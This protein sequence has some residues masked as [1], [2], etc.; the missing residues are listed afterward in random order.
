[1]IYLY[2]LTGPF[3]SVAWGVYYEILLQLVW[4]TYINEHIATAGPGDVT[5]AQEIMRGDLST[6]CCEGD[7]ASVHTQ[8]PFEQ[9]HADIL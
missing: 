1:M 8:R 7:H 4:R 2:E 3:V 6:L 9:V 5:R